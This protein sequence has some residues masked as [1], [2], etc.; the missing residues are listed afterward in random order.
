MTYGLI[1]ERDIF[2]NRT[3]QQGKPAAREEY[4]VAT[5]NVFLTG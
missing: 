4:S 2:T 1:P 5:V 3:L